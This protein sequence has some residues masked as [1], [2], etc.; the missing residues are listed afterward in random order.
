LCPKAME[1]PLMAS[2]LLVWGANRVINDSV[3]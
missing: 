3:G 2:L 1:R